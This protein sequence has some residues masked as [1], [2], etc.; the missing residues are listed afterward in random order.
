MTTAVDRDLER[1]ARA[2]HLGDWMF[3]QFAGDVR[4]SVVE[5]GAGLG[6]FSARILDAGAAE[7][8]L[9]EPSPGVL[10][11]LHERFDP[12][13][14]VTIAA[15]ELPEAPALAARAGTAD[16]AVC[17][18]VLEH[19][20]DDAGAVRSLAAALKPGGVLFLL[21]PAH[22]A[23]FGSLDRAY[24]HHRRYTPQ[25]LRSL[26][27]GAGLD[28]LDL[29]HFNLLGVPGWWLSSRRGSAELSDGAL[30]A[31]ERIVV[32][33]RRLERRRRPPAGLSLVLR[34]QRP[35]RA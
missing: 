28:V 11:A 14:R 29:Y 30:A 17:Q 26:A 9:I 10:P 8:L 23:L 20:L 6:T 25:R 34:A 3:E 15:E 21:V 2:R 31:Y 1:L 19:I 13:P 33:W 22:P 32:G 12:D 18:N 27:A 35:A 24:E 7:L 5:V 4:G 16:L